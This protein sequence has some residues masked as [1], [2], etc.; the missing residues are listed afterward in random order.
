MGHYASAG[1]NVPLLGLIQPL[2]S[3]ITSVRACESGLL[4]SSRL[5]PQICPSPADLPALPP[6][7]SPSSTLW[8]LCNLRALGPRGIACPSS[9]TGVA[10]QQGS[11]RFWSC[12]IISKYL[13]APIPTICIVIYKLCKHYHSSTL[14]TYICKLNNYIQSKYN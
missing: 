3:S 7:S 13:W 14:F 8:T 2:S 12:T 10:S 11:A 1:E 4:G 6:P 9:A 5:Q